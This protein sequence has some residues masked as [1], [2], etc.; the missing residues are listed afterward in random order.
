MFSHVIVGW[1]IADHMPAVAELVVDALHIA[2]W[3]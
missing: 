2:T 3:R 1:S